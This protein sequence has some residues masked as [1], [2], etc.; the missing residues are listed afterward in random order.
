MPELLITAVGNDRP[1]LVDGLT[2]YLFDAGANLADSQMVNLRGRFAYVVLVEADEATLRSIETNVTEAGRE[3]GLHVTV[4]PQAP[5]SEE[6]PAGLAYRFKAHALDQPGLA[7]RIA[8][9]LH[10][11]G[12]NIEQLRSRL[13]P[14]PYGGRPRF[15]IEL[16]ITLPPSVQV[17]QLRDQLTRLCDSLNCDFELQPM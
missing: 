7:H 2:R 13:H 3:L 14:G 9:L 5:S 1:G 11:E 15:S 4:A 6:H 10:G 12:I 16:Q 8:H 17:R